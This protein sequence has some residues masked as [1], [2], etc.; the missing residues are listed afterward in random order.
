MKQ[1]ESVR[2][3]WH[4]VAQIHGFLFVERSSRRIPRR[5]DG[6]VGKEDQ[7]SLLA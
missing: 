3:L 6:Q 7:S 4:R 2:G 5:T 1:D